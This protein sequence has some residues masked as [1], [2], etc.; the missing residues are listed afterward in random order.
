MI[1]SYLKITRESL[2]TKLC[3]SPPDF[4]F[5]MYYHQAINLIESKIYKPLAPKSKKKPPQNVRSIYFQNKGLEFINI[6]R[7]VRDMTQI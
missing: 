5:S 4:I 6:A 1:K 7:N 3:Y 2:S